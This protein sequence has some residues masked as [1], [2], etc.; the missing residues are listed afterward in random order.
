MAVAIG[1]R[2]SDGTATVEAEPSGLAIRRAPRLGEEVYR[3]I[4]TR[5]MSQRIKPGSRLSID[6]LARELGVSQTPI[7][8]ALSRLEAL[9]LVVKTPLVGFSAAGQ[10]DRDR[11]DQLYELRLLL[12]P[13]AARKAAASLSAEQLGALR[14][15]ADDMRAHGSS[16]GDF[17]R[18]DGAF[19]DLIAGAGGNELI[20]ETLA[21]QH[22]H[23]HL[24]RLFPHAKATTDADEE[25]ADLIE[26][27]GARDG[28]R[29]ERAMR[30]HVKR[31]YARFRSVFD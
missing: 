13:H 11:L 17:A 30:H 1:G 16:Y 31:S 15:L 19:H 28:P 12:E 3:S 20:R 23:V 7:R 29:A 5:L 26:A 10:I 24:F 2:Q 18:T 25:H 9:G 22:I 27:L 6:S 14:G 4:Y 8:E 21:K